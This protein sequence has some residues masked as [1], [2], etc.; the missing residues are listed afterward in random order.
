MGLFAFLRLVFPVPI[1]VPLLILLPHL[2]CPFDFQQIQMVKE[3]AM[4][5]EYCNMFLFLK[6]IIIIYLIKYTHLY[7]F[8]CNLY[9]HYSCHGLNYVLPNCIVWVKALS[10]QLIIFGDRTL[11]EL[12]KVKRSC[13]GGALI[14]LDWRP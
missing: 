8:Y 12:I 7:H 5:L 9:V 2:E 10:F 4:M 1:S 13:K 3:I 11:K 6:K 14:Q